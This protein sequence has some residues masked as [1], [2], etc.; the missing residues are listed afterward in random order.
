MAPTLDEP[1]KPSWLRGYWAL[2]WL[3]AGLAVSVPEWLKRVPESTQSTGL[4]KEYL[5]ALAAVPWQATATAI[6]LIAI[7]A[8]LSR[9]RGYADEKRLW[10]AL[11]RERESPQAKK[12][13][14]MQLRVTPV[15]GGHQIAHGELF[16]FVSSYMDGFPDMLARACPHAGIPEAV[17]A[18]LWSCADS[19]IAN[20]GL[21]ERTEG[22]GVWI[23]RLLPEGRAFRDHCHPLALR[24]RYQRLTAK[25]ERSGRIVRFLR[26]HPMQVWI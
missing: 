22:D 16:F 9:W 10:E 6:V 20:D 5:D 7:A 18:E 3:L 19:L 8:A 1:Q 25:V 26:A 21:Y 11:E 13:R 15:V 24:A 12:W 4:V 2:L 14:A 17:F 23:Y